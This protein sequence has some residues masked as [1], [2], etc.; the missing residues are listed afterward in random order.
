MGVLLSI[1]WDFFF[2]DPQFMRV[3][4]GIGEDGKKY[5]AKYQ[6]LFD[7]SHSH[8][9]QSDLIW[10]V[11]ATQFLANG[12][13]LPMVEWGASIWGMFDLSEAAMFVADDH[14]RIASGV[15][16]DRRF[17]IDR[18]ISLDAHHDCGYSEYDKRELSCENWVKA[19]PMPTEIVYPDWKHHAMKMDYSD[20]VGLFAKPNRR[21]MIELKFMKQFKK[22]NS[23]PIKVDTLF[24]CRSSPWVPTW[25][26]GEFSKFLKSCPIYDRVKWVE[27]IRKRVFSMN[28]IQGL[29]D[30]AIEEHAKFTALMA[31]S[32]KGKEL[33]CK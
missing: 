18:V 17:K 13:D 31:E 21:A 32:E 11:R 15:V 33:V 29:V 10:D 1:D 12:F 4:R 6:Q 22:A 23:A 24:I 19:Y 16:Y 20:K 9:F 14:V 5:F 27:R 28:R 7:W 25:C 8:K 30:K 26:D 2:P 3:P